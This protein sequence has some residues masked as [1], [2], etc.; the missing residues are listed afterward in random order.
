MKN[1]FYQAPFITRVKFL[2]IIIPALLL[3]AA[4]CKKEEEPKHKN[5]VTATINGQPWKSECMESTLFGCTSGDLQY[6]PQSGFL[7]L[8]A[9]NI[10]RDTGIGIT[11]ENVFKIGGYRIPNK[12]MCAIIVKF[13]PCGRR[14]HYIDEADPQEIEII[15]IDNEKKIIEGKFHYIGHDTTCL[16]EPVHITNGYFKVKYRP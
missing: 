7:Y 16:S 6:Y 9:D 2:W 11:L 3:T 5:I 1:I 4:S 12:Q 10:T 13:E 14:R 15:S 8:G